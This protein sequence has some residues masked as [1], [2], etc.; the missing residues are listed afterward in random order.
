M[1]GFASCYYSK[2]TIDLG[3]A[4]HFSRRQGNDYMRGCAY[5]GCVKPFDASR[6]E[7]GVREGMR[8]GCRV[9]C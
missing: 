1:G 6:G 2:G 5:T 7:G 8:C 9:L 3:A 4:P